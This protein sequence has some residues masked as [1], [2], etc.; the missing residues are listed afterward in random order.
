ML[1][2]SFSY[3]FI[4][5]LA[6][7]SACTLHTIYIILNFLTLSYSPS[8][9][10]SLSLTLVFGLAPSHWLSL[11]FLFPHSR[12]PGSYYPVSVNN[13][14]EVYIPLKQHGQSSKQQCVE[15]VVDHLRSLPYPPVLHLHAAHRS[16]TTAHPT[17]HYTYYSD[18][19]PSSRYCY[20]SHLYNLLRYL[21]F[22]ASGISLP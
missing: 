18:V 17:A 22:L 1:G 7:V 21:T 3:L 10:F 16:L 2:V 19:L 11:H 4:D 14:S 20:L 9:P 13:N 12:T 8:F 15:H 6:G 5:S